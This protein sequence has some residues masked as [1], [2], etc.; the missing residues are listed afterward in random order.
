MN[1]GALSSRLGLVGRPALAEELMVLRDIE[2]VRL[3]GCAAALH[4]PFDRSLA[5][6]RER[7]PAARGSP[8]RAKSRRTTSPSTRAIARRPTTPSSKCTRRC[9]V[10]RDVDALARALASGE[11]DAVATDHAPARQ[12]NSRTCPSTKRPPGC[13]ISS[14]PRRSP[15]RR[16]ARAPSAHTFFSAHESR[17]RRASPSCAREDEHPGHSAHGGAMRPARTPTSSSLIPRARWTR[18]REHLASRATQHPLRRPGDD[19]AGSRPRRAGC[20]RRARGS[21]GVSRPRALLVLADGDDLRGL[22][23]RVPAPVGGHDG[24]VRLQHLA[25]RLPRGHH[26]PE[27][28][29]PDH[30]L[31]LSPHWQLRR[32]ALGRR[33]ACVPGARA[34]SCAN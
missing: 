31:H 12:S 4:A 10:A 11:I 26:R 21:V 33:G 28:R 30:R 14:T 23:R 29:R 16:S 22:R 6:A 3:T 8:S 15:T 34:S 1:E 19:A 7:R 18:A 20:S 5:R 9:A 32:D 24:R 2:L 17:S 25:Q 27:L 13:S